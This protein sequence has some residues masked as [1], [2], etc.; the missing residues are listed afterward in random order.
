[1]GSCASARTPC[2]SPTGPR[3]SGRRRFAFRNPPVP[4]SGTIAPN[5]GAPDH[6]RLQVGGDGIRNLRLTLITSARSA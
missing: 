2:P 3:A 6:A 5:P 4:R 1:L